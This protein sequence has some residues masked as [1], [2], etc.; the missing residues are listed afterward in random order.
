MKRLAILGATG[1]IG[2]TTLSVVERYP[3]RF[4]VVSL[5]AGKN[6]DRLARQIRFFRPDMVSWVYIAS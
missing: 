1:S 6:I 4:R 2:V 5:A 3:E